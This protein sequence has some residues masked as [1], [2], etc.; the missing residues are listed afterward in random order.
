EYDDALVISLRITNAL[1]KNILINTRSSTNIHY[2]DTFQKIDLS[3]KNLQLISLNLIGFTRDSKTLLGTIDL[4]VIFKF[5]S[6]LK[7]VEI[8]FLVADISFTYNIIIERLTLNHICAMLSI[9]CMT[10]KFLNS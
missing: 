10:L 7:I 1:V 9:Y 3:A 8:K 6:C 2:H 5:D 4:Y